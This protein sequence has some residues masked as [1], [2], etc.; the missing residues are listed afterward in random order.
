MSV[1][2]GLFVSKSA[3]WLLLLSLGAVALIGATRGYT[4]LGEY[5]ASIK[6]LEKRLEANRSYTEQIQTEAQKSADKARVDMQAL[7]DLL[8]GA[9]DWPN[10]PVP[11]EVSKHLSNSG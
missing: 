10:E 9:G 8:Q 5:K 3:P 2:R 6:A 11:E 7:Q 1:L 4:A